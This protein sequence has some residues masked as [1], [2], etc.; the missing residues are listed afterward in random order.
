[1]PINSKAKGSE[2]ERKVAKLLSKW[3]KE[4][5][6]RTPMSG[7]LHWKEDNRVAGDI[8]T[9]P[10]S[11][12]PFTTECK[13]REEWEFEQIIKGTGEVEK[14]W[15]Q[16]ITDGERVGLKPLLIFSKNFAPSYLMMYC[17]DF[18]KILA[19]KGVTTLP[20]NYFI[21]HKKGSS[22]RLICILDDFVAAVTKEDVIG[23][24]VTVK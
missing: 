9:P 11:V 15:T 19:Y 3:W 8:V 14:W 1:M 22:P 18:D 10:N 5:F 24:L 16:A 2:F 7:G 13:K 21:L 4:Q 23:A 6:H 12:Y 20:F 17:E